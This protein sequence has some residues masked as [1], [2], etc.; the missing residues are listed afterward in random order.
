MKSSAIL[1][2]LLSTLLF[3]AITGCS[4]DKSPKNLYLYE[5]IERFGVKHC[6]DTLLVIAYYGVGEKDTMTL[7]P[8][9]GGYYRR[10]VA[11]GEQLILAV[12]DF[13]QDTVYYHKSAKDFPGERV[14]IAAKENGHFTSCIYSFYSKGAYPTIQIDYDEN[15][16]IESISGYLDMRYCPKNKIGENRDPVKSATLRMQQQEKEIPSPIELP[17][18]LLN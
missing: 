12:K 1:K 17:N 10:R 9:N 18:S 13:P 3:A 15:F 16:K 6:N 7:Y 11:F 14:T 2:F 8:K 4:S 5:G